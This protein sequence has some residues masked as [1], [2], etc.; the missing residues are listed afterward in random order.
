MYGTYRRFALLAFSSLLASQAFAAAYVPCD[1][2]SFTQMQ[3]AA[4]GRGVGRYVVGDVIANRVEAFRLYFGTHV[5]SVPINNAI[6]KLYIED[7]DLTAQEE[8]AFA[9]Y[10]KFYN[11]PPMGYQKQFDLR[12]VPAGSPV[13]VP[14]SAANIDMVNAGPVSAMELLHNLSPMSVPKP[15]GGTVS[16]PN[17][18]VN[19]YT[20]LN[21]GPSQNAFLS[22]LGS[23]A[24]FNISDTLTTAVT[25]LS[26]LHV[27]NVDHVLTISFTVT[28]TDGSH[29]GAYVDATQL[30]Q[31]I[32]VNARTAV[33]SHGNNIPAA[34]TAV[35]GNGKQNYDFSGR[36]NIT[37]RSNM[38]NQIGSFGINPPNTEKFACTSVAGGSIHCVPY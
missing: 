31:Q 8:A 18:G 22:W 38:R 4:L 27:T 34:V 26:V 13:G 2:C 24:T 12:I 3:G 21:D 35:A 25:A 20:V 5:N 36:G 9:A 29:I 10:V 28:F 15:G 19:A 37:D 11:A 32:V 30:P 1:G 16:Y 17:P 14:N 33:D 7:G 23:L 6:G